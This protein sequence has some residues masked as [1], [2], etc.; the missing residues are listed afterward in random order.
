MTTAMLVERKVESRQGNIR[1]M[2]IVFPILAACFVVLRFLARWKRGMRLG[3]DDWLLL[4]GMVCTL[5]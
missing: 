4:I 1:T 2:M 3:I 5:L